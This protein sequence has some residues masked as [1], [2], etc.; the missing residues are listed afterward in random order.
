MTQVMTVGNTN[1]EEIKL[2]KNT[3]KACNVVARCAEEGWFFE[4]NGESPGP[5]T[6]QDMDNHDFETQTVAKLGVDPKEI[7]I[8]TLRDYERDDA[9]ARGTRKR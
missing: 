3:S 6:F 8:A 1:F 5:F 9:S 4:A 7:V 2:L